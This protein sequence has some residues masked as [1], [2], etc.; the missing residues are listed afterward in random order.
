M[1]GSEYFYGA[2]ADNDAGSHGIAGRHSWHNRGVGNTQV[3]DSIDLE[4]G[5]Y[6]R[7]G[8]TPHLGGTAL[9]PPAESSIA[10]E[11]IQRRPVQVA[12]HHLSLNEWAK[13]GGVA[14]LTAEFHTGHQGMKIVR[15]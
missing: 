10:D 13:R 3:F 4:V 8:V 2:F 6:D 15:L 14:D 7:H 9:M 12:G 1:I 5:V 11:V